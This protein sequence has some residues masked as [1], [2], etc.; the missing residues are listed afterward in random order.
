MKAKRRTSLTGLGLLLFLFAGAAQAT[1]GAA[2]DGAQS[3]EQAA[4]IEEQELLTVQRH[5]PGRIDWEPLRGLKVAFKRSSAAVGGGRKPLML[6]KAGMVTAIITE[7]E[8]G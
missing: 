1:A 3:R 6:A 2:Q 8:A 4:L 7:L 5:Q